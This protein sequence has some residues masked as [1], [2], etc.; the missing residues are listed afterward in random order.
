[1][2]NELLNTAKAIHTDAAENLVPGR[3]RTISEVLDLL[4]GGARNLASVLRKPAGPLLVVPDTVDNGTLQSVGQR[5]RS[6]AA[7]G[8]S[9]H[10]L[11]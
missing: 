8:R 2:K 5:K 4:V 11:T 1:V 10:Q 9:S 7:M 3:S 6:L